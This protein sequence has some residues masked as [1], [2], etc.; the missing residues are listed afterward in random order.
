MDDAGPSDPVV[1]SDSDEDLDAIAGRQRDTMMTSKRVDMYGSGVGGGFIHGTSAA[2]FLRGTPPTAHTASPGR[3]AQPELIETEA[4]PDGGDA[5]DADESAVERMLRAFLRDEEPASATHGPTS[6]ADRLVDSRQGPTASS[7]EAT[8]TQH[9][10]HQRPAWLGRL[11]DEQRLAYL[12]QAAERDRLAKEDAAERQRRAYAAVVPAKAAMVSPTVSPMRAAVPQP[13]AAFDD[14][15][16]E[17]EDR[18][19]RERQE[20]HAR[21]AQLE[22]D[23]LRRERE[24]TMMISAGSSDGAP[25]VLGPSQALRA[26]SPTGTSGTSTPDRASNPELPPRSPIAFTAPRTALQEP[27]TA[28]LH[29]PPASGLSGTLP[30]RPTSPVP[31]GMRTNSASTAAVPSQQPRERTASPSTWAPAPPQVTQAAQAPST[32]D[33]VVHREPDSQRQAAVLLLPGAPSTFRPRAGSSH[34]TST[35]TSAR[36]HN[37]VPHY[38]QQPPQRAAGS[39]AAQQNDLSRQGAQQQSWVAHNDGG[40]RVDPSTDV[41]RAALRR[42]KEVIAPS[43]SPAVSAADVSFGKS[44]TPRLSSSSLNHAPPPR[45]LES[46]PHFAAREPSRPQTAEAAPAPHQTATSWDG[47]VSPPSPPTRLSSAMQ[48]GHEQRQHA[49]P[50]HPHG[51]TANTAHNEDD[52]ERVLAAF[53]SRPDASAGRTATRATDVDTARHR[54]HRDHDHHATERART[55]SGDHSDTEE[56][57]RTASAAARDSF[58]AV[59]TPHY[60]AHVRHLPRYMQATQ[61]WEQHLVDEPR[62]LHDHDTRQ[63]QDEHGEH[64]HFHF[65]SATQPAAAAVRESPTRSHHVLNDSGASSRG[66]S[67]NTSLVAATR[68][69]RRG[70]SAEPLALPPWH[71]TGRHVKNKDIPPLVASAPAQGEHPDGPKRQPSRTR[72]QTPER[73]RSASSGVAKRSNFAL[74]SSSA[75]PP[76]FPPSTGVAQVSTRRLSPHPRPAQRIDI[77]TDKPRRYR[78]V[79]PEVPSNATT[80]G[81]IAT[82]SSALARRFQAA[83]QEVVHIADVEDQVST[84]NRHAAE[85]EKRQQQEAWRKGQGANYWD[86]AAAEADMRHALGRIAEL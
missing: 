86:A 67:S 16:E 33:V 13:A 45:T 55:A 36:S 11:M 19:D 9:Q 79:R 35:V 71:S 58:A 68:V 62:H 69:P 28:S 75:P 27:A 46:R 61:A 49:A 25:L 77:R 39:G 22:S 41:V 66:G 78:L 34:C 47:I 43:P 51:D 6:E 81:A 14:A 52:D 37:E 63:G 72:S 10:P 56:V 38:Q 74:S 8:A 76:A 57:E 20:L 32:R 59:R 4:D 60:L 48:R 12:D 26:S 44:A 7:S 80:T 82:P 5:D 2:D 42:L 85:F 29:L 53:H 23:V 73:T 17:V 1:S 70:V 31:N 21:L 84:F 54:D 30:A 65:E 15:D 3:Q 64:R 18:I 83:P 50:Q 24:I 40:A